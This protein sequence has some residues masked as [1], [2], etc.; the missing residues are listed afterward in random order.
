[1]LAHIANCSLSLSARH[2]GVCRQAPFTPLDGPAYWTQRDGQ[3]PP[4][5]ARLPT[6][7]PPDATAKASTS[8]AA[9]NGASAGGAAK[10]VEGWSNQ[11]TRTGAHATATS[12]SADA[13]PMQWVVEV[14][15]ATD[16]QGWQYGSQFAHLGE[17]REGGRACRRGSGAPQRSPLPL[18]PKL[19]GR[20]S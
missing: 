20:L 19:A 3:P 13:D 11:S 9:S 18:P 2:D 1:M 17:S 15:P 16:Q 12:A 7:E 4:P 8:A 6:D 5:G 10:A 14:T